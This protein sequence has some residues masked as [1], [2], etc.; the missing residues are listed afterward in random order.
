MT[1]TGAASAMGRLA[2]MVAGMRAE[3]TPL[4]HRLAGFARRVSY[5]IIALA[6]AVV[7]VGVA[8]EGIASASRV[9]IFAVALAVA[10]VPEGLP[11]VLT[12]TLALGVERMARRRAVV[13]R[14]AAVEAL[15]S[16]TVVA[17]DKTGTLTE[18]RMEVRD[19]DA[20][21]RDGAFAAMVLANDAEP[22]SHAGDPID[23]GLLAYVAA[24][25]HD[26]AAIRRD[27]TRT[28][29]RPFDSATKFA[30]VSGDWRGRP[31]S[32]VK[33]APEI[34]LD[35]CALDPGERADWVGR[36][37]AH[38]AAGHRVLALARGEG[39][40]NTELAW[41][42]VVL[43]W[44]PPR[45]EVAD[46]VAHA[47]AA[48]VRVVMITGD[49]AGTACAVAQPPSGSTP[50]WCERCRPRPHGRRGAPAG[51]AGDPGATR[52]SRRSTS[53]GSW[54]RSKRTVSWSR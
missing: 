12:V 24:S 8:V 26:A 36:I 11:A 44:D 21:D 34:V 6:A 19:L 43:L 48:G 7:A 30:R 53:S 9:M 39:A 52:A 3:P 22:G 32:F 47:R 5:W 33:G 40:T 16:V 51:N 28:A 15:G 49:H 27:F 4:E 17:T 37:E 31:T 13:R 23:L 1:A 46:A 35:R 25:G 41:L 54:R 29:T 45:P 50:P 2:G 42:G 18:N 20:A 38:A 14:L 10:A